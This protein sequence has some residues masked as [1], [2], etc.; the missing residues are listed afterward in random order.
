LE[1]GGEVHALR[2]GKEFRTTAGPK[3][4]SG[5]VCEG[6]GGSLKKADRKQTL[7]RRVKK[8]GEKIV[9]KKKPSMR[10]STAFWK[11]TKKERKENRNK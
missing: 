4:V 5:G 2:T 1:K 6:V 10:V 11:N 7:A 9:E 3:V 8:R